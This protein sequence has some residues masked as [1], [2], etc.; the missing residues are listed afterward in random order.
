MP[1]RVD[2]ADRNQPRFPEGTR[3]RVLERGGRNTERIGV[4]RRVVFHHK[5]RCWN[6]YLKS[7]E[8]SVSKRYV[9]QD[10]ELDL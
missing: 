10:L 1:R 2:D 4:V 3:V 9:A 5:D 7:G 6:Y 8:R